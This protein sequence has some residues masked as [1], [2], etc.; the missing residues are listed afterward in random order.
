MWISGPQMPR[1]AAKMG[2]G[3]LPTYQP[4]QLQKEEKFFLLNRYLGQ[5]QIQFGG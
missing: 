2:Q 5:P 4:S 1:L 3:H